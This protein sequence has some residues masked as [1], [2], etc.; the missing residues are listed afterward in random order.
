[1]REPTH[2][3]TNDQAS[4]KRKTKTQATHTVYSSQ[5]DVGRHDPVTT[6]LERSQITVTPHGTT[7]NAGDSRV[8]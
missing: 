4:Q 6:L 7:R 5:L 8:C 3:R 1:M 2:P